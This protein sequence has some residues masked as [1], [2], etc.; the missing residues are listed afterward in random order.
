MYTIENHP[1]WSKTQNYNTDYKFTSI[2]IY[3]DSAH[4]YKAMDFPDK[5]YKFL[6][7]TKLIQFYGSYKIF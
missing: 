4:R 1:L 3:E 2:C 6:F 7:H 5:L